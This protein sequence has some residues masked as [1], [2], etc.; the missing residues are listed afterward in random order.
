MANIYRIQ[1]YDSMMRRYF[2]TG[3]IDIMLNNTSIILIILPYFQ[4]FDNV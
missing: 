2:C 1:E 3:S 4:Q